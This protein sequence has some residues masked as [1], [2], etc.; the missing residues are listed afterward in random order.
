MNKKPNIYHANSCPPCP[1]NVSLGD[2]ITYWLG[3]GLGS[4]KPKRAAGT[5]GTLGGLVVALPFI[6]FGFVAFFILTILSLLA[7]SY[8]C[9]RTSQLMGIDDDPHIVFDEWAGMWLTLLP[10]V[11]VL[12][13]LGG[14]DYLYPN[15]AS[16]WLMIGLGF[17]LFR[18]F[19]VV[20]PAPISW[21]DKH[22]S[23]GFGIMLDDVLAG[24]MAALLTV[25]IV[26]IFCF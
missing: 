18:L 4:G 14:M 2:K 21:A 25:I 24:V 26:F 16:F 23:G 19:D 8:I 22:V 10:S 7:G 15:T 20:K 3:V 12:T 9:G 17:G 6:W 11:F 5:W 1:P 13:A